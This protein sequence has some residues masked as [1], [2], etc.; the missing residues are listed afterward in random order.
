MIGAV[1]PEVF[2]QRAAGEP[3]ASSRLRIGVADFGA[4]W[5]AYDYKVTLPQN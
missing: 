4:R 1:G 2:G 3:R 5:E